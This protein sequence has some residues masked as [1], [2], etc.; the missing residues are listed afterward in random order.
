MKSSDLLIDGLGR[1]REVVHDVAS[2]LTAAQLAYRQGPKANSIGWLIWHLT[3][4]QDDHLADAGGYDQV[5]MKDGWAERF[6][7]PSDYTAT[8]WS[9]NPGQVS[10]IKPPSP[11]V[12]IDYHEAVHAR[13]VSY[14]RTLTDA[15]LDRI[16]DERW[17]PPVTLG[18]RL[19]SV[20]DDDAQHAGQAAYLRGL[21][22]AS[23]SA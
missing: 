15:D 14:V 1:V 8:G 21:I 18:V 3:R 22:E 17:D 12:L 6:G 9:H 23:D 4:V 2:G 10:E 19:I 11:D 16:V 13:S 20:I 5:W 7:L